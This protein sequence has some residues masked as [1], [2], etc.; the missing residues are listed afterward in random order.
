MPETIFDRI[1]QK[2]E[3]KGVRESRAALN[4]GLSIAGIRNIRV[5]NSAPRSDTLEKLAAY[6]DVSPDWLLT[7]RESAPAPINAVAPMV[8][9]MVEPGPSGSFTITVTIQPA[10]GDAA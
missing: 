4:A 7:G 5:R 3:E 1:Q 8:A 2:L 9:V 10:T 6:F